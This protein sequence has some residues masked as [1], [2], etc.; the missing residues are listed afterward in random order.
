M[1]NIGFA[2]NSCI[3][4]E[5]NKESQIKYSIPYPNNL[6]IPDNYNYRAQEQ[7]YKL[8]ESYK[9]C[10]YYC[11]PNGKKWFLDTYEGI[12][13]NMDI[14]RAQKSRNKVIFYGKK[15]YKYAYSWLGQDSKPIKLNPVN[16]ANV[17]TGESNWK[18]E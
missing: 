8:N 15:G 18:V 17:I 3:S 1:V 4:S 6:L 10:I 16:E 11:P 13:M 2:Q 5:L 9:F 14:S 7:N 12:I